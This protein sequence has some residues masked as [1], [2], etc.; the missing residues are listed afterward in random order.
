MSRSSGAQELRSSLLQ[1]AGCLWIS[2]QQTE[3]P[4]L[5]HQGRLR[6]RGKLSL[7]RCCCGMRGCASPSLS[8]HGHRG[9]QLPE[10]SQG[11]RLLCPERRWLRSCSLSWQPLL[12]SIAAA[13]S[14][15]AQPAQCPLHRPLL[16]AGAAPHAKDCLPG[17]DTSEQASHLTLILLSITSTGIKLQT[18]IHGQVCVFV[19][20]PCLNH[21]PRLQ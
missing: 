17:W 21:P 4:N 5:W 10:P 15:R 11:G 19:R 2:T 18:F 1:G 7:P 9:W 8:S 16:A 14:L 20:G 12:V 3:H 13:L 6:G